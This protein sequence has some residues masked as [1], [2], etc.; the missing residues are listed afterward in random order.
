[1][2]KTDPFPETKQGTGRISYLVSLTNS[3]QDQEEGRKRTEFQTQVAFPNRQRGKEDV[4][5]TPRSYPK[6]DAFVQVGLSGRG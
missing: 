6:T 5:Q 1:M 2:I 4:P 3:K